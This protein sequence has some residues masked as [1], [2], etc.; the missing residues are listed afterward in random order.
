MTLLVFVVVLDALF[1]MP[2]RVV[3]AILTA[4]KPV[5]TVIA[6]MK[7]MLLLRRALVE[8]LLRR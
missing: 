4:V 1:P 2:V 6:G 8:A 5:I 3:M 7:L